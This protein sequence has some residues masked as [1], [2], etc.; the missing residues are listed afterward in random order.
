MTYEPMPTQ[1]ED[2]NKV[3]E[4][5]HAIL[6]AEAGTGKTITAID[7]FKVGGYKKMIVIAP[8]IAL[9]MW[10]NELRKHLGF[11]RV[12]V[13]RGGRGAM[14]KQIAKTLGGGGADAIVTTFDLC[15]NKNVAELLRKFAFQFDGVFCVLDEAQAA[16]TP[17][18]GRTQAIYG[19][20]QD[21]QYTFLE[22]VDDALIMSGDFVMAYSNDWFVH[23][24]FA[25]PEILKHYGVET[26]QKFMDKFCV[27]ERKRHHPKQQVVKPRPV[28]DRN[29]DT[30]IRL[31]KDCKVIQRTLAEVEPNLPPVTYRHVD[32]GVSKVPKVK[33][34]GMTDEQFLSALQNPDSELAKIRR[35]LGLAKVDEFCEYAAGQKPPLLI[36][37]WH[38]DVVA[39]IKDALQEHQP[40]WVV[41][42]VTGATSTQDR[43]HI[44][45]G[46]NIG[47]V[48]VI[49][50]QIAAMNFSWNLQKVCKHVLFAEEIPSHG[51]H[52]QF[53]S[54][55]V[56]KGQQHSVQVDQ[57]NS[58]HE[59]DEV[60]Q[61]IRFRKRATKEAMRKGLENE[62]A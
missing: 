56:R 21:G 39:A 29:T 12:Q 58:Q 53:M 44:Q 62:Q 61:S 15:R 3:L 17:D 7:A 35:L 38:T 11:K 55:V 51:M 24:K 36:G 32:V 54:R 2:R 31:L 60:L 52:H 57:C 41:R 8:K 1:I 30:L 13:I 46:F 22:C 48:D 4:Y 40:N 6:W 20:H 19:T 27:V 59:I 9:T 50:G 45:E 33:V 43:D 28:G 34:S 42:E 14:F 26:Y 25:R 18:S 37:A 23:L 49:V 47:T 10:H 16:K 5:N